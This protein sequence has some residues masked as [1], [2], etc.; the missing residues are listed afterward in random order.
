MCSCANLE[1]EEFFDRINRM[2]KIARSVE[3]ILPDAFFPSC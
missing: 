1:E 3:W 2:N